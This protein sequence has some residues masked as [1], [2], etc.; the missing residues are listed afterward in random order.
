[1]TASG[2][3]GDPTDHT[4]ENSD[5]QSGG[6]G[7]PFSDEPEQETSAPDVDPDTGTDQDGTPVENPSG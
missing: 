3:T 5:E 7:G 4:I 6:Y 1:M 2:P